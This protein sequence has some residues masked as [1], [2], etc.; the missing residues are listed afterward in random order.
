MLSF[1]LHSSR[2]QCPFCGAS[3]SLRREE[4]HGF[5]QVRLLSW[6]GLYPWECGLCRRVSFHRHRGARANAHQSLRARN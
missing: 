6:F 2:F 5:V 3:R 1:I 4:R